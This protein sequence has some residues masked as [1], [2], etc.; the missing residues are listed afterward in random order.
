M[1]S[2]VFFIV[3]TLTVISYISSLTSNIDGHECGKLKVNEC[4]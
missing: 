2:S 4:V 3:M 1:G